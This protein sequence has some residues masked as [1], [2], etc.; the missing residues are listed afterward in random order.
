MEKMLTAEEFYHQ[1]I[2]DNT[3]GSDITD[4]MNAYA[5]YHVKAALEA[6]ANEYYPKDKE[7]FEIVAGRFI[8]AYPPENI[9]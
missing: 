9:K 7:N 3:I 6:A 4:L 2:N 1:A 8:N 5:K